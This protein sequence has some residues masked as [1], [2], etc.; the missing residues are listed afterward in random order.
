ML[1]VS[2]CIDADCVDADVVVCLSESE[3]AAKEI[4]ATEAKQQ[5]IRFFMTSPFAGGVPIQLNS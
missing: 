1:F 2:V 4:S 3:Q 5:R